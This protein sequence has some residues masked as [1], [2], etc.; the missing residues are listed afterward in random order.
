MGPQRLSPVSTHWTSPAP[1]T[2]TSDRR[3]GSYLA[4]EGTSA[5]PSRLSP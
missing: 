5:G 4:A 1:A 3:A 2:P